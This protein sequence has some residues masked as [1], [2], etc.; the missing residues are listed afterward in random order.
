MGVYANDE[1]SLTGKQQ[2]PPLHNSQQQRELN[3]IEQA[4]KKLEEKNRVINYHNNCYVV[5]QVAP[6]PLHLRTNVLGAQ[7]KP[8]APQV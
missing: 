3:K 7:V 8:P 6:K 4:I 1:L 2:C 5:E